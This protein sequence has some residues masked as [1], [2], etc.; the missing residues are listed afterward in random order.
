MAVSSLSHGL[1]KGKKQSWLT[2]QQKKIKDFY[3][4]KSSRPRW[5]Y[6]RMGSTEGPP[7]LGFLLS[8][9]AGKVGTSHPPSHGEVDE[10]VA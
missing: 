7:E 3:L 9:C 8:R 5:M 2:L 6:S 10:T 4:E 1:G